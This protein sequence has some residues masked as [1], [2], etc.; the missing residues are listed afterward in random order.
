[1]YQL[2]KERFKSPAHVTEL[3]SPFEPLSSQPIP[4]ANDDR[5]EEEKDEDNGMLDSECMFYM[6]MSYDKKIDYLDKEKSTQAAIMLLKNPD[7]NRNSLI[8]N[9]NGSDIKISA[10]ERNQIQAI[11][12]KNLKNNSRKDSEPDFRRDSRQ[13]GIKLPEKR[14]SG[15]DF[16]KDSPSRNS[17]LEPDSPF[18][19][20]SPEPK[21]Y[22]NST[23]PLSK[24]AAEGIDDEFEESYFLQIYEDFYNAEALREQKERKQQEDSIFVD[25]PSESDKGEISDIDF[26]SD[27]ELQDIAEDIQTECFSLSF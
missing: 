14:I 2:L 6:S 22:S 19:P 17:D 8:S 4:I 23:E 5:S 1:M 12:S 15:L 16:I 13:L 26:D 7:T 3:P 24:T 21:L 11:K 20:I 18:Y 10:I 25:I 27:R 9:H